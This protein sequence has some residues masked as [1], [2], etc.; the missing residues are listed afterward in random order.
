M[1]MAVLRNPAYVRL[2][3]LAGVL[4][5]IT[6]WHA[7]ALAQDAAAAAPAS[8][9]HWAWGLTT[10]P[11]F[12]RDTILL[13]LLAC[14]TAIAIIV[15][16]ILGLAPASPVLVLSMV[17]VVLINGWRIARALREKLQVILSDEERELFE[18]VFRQL[19][20]VEFMRLLKLGEW[21]TAAPST[22]LA[23]EGEQLDELIVLGRGEV[24]I[25]RHG[26]PV[27]QASHGALI[28]EMSYLQGGSATAT[29]RATAPTRYLAWSK[30]E[31]AKLLRRDP[32]LH[33]ALKT[34]LSLDLAR[35][36]GAPD[37]G[38]PLAV[39]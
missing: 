36:L 32:S 24:T 3:G 15:L 27:A 34:V 12:A 8:S 33:L 30:S 9:G 21:R 10:V 13:R 2:L 29:V 14:L 16:T 7:A 19:S 37:T 23:N 25:E 1:I 35:K 20:P 26:Q 38:D 28:G 22:I 11:F 5:G 31:L 4:C 17:L 18:T 6:M 39:R